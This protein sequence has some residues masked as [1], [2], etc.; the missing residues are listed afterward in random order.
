LFVD[1][2]SIIWPS[3]SLYFAGGLLGGDG[4]IYGIPYNAQQVLK[5]LGEDVSGSTESTESIE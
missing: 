3:E 4:S 5:K 1:H 2:P